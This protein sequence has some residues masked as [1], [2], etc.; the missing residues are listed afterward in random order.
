MVQ[1]KGPVDEHGKRPATSIIPAPGTGMRL[2]SAFS[3][4]THEPGS[5][6]ASTMQ[7]L[8]R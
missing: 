2:H 8:A 7:E 4:H 6:D 1:A 3:M 5:S